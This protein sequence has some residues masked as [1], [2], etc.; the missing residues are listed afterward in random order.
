M[1]VDITAVKIQI[2]T[3]LWVAALLSRVGTFAAIVGMGVTCMMEAVDSC[4]L[5]I[6]VD[7]V[8]RITQKCIVLQPRRPQSEL[9]LIQ[10]CTQILKVAIIAK[11]N[12]DIKLI[13]PKVKFVCY[14]RAFL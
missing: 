1:T 9:N 8:H 3:F 10:S 4:E 7:R 2:V 6:T 5:L 14:S 13:L 11:M 12:Y